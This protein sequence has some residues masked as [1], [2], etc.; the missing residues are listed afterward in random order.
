MG[1]QYEPRSIVIPGSTSWNSVLDYWGVDEI[2][3]YDP[4]YPLFSMLPDG[5]F[6]GVVSTDVLEHC[7]EEDIPWIVAEI[8]GYAERFVFANIACY[9]ALRHLP[10]G[11]NVHCTIR[12]TEWWQVVFEEAAR[13]RPGVQWEVW[14]K[15]QES[16]ATERRFFEQRIG[17]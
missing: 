6:D 3:C 2:A 5:M 10:N 17:T 7:P 11:E 4:G 14:T 13:C 16:G 15:H 8:F 1:M 9:P 12:S